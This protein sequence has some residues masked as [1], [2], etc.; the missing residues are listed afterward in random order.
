MK[1][2]RTPFLARRSAELVFQGIALLSI[3]TALTVI[4]ALIGQTV[5][6]GS[7]R[8]SWH[9][10]TSPPSRNPAQAGIYPALMGSFYLMGLLLVIALPLGVGAAVYLEEYAPKNRLTR[11]I[12]L[13]IANLA[14]VPSIIYGLLGLDLFVRVLQLGRSLIAGALILSLLILPIVIM[15]AREAIKTVPRSIREASLALGATKWQTI[16]H[17]VLPNAFPGI[18]TGCILAFSRAIGETAPL[19]T[20]GALTY[21][22]FAPDN[23]FSPFTALPIQ[24]FNWVSRPQAAFHENAAAAIMVLLVLLLGMNSIAILLRQKMQRKAR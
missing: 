4:G 19:V 15:S 1:E 3:I 12:E 11:L 24:A 20:M 18:M 7:S 21:V 6:D 13:N 8:L 14:G 17:N 23:L 5:Y 9:F 2:P 16:W 10:L 22:A